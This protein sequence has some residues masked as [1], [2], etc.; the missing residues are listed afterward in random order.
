MSDSAQ[1]RREAADRIHSAAIHLLRRVHEVDAEAMG[2]SPARASALSVLVFGGARSLTELAAAERVTSA[3]M[4]KLVTGMEGEG[5]VRRYPDVNDA[6]S[7]RLEATAKG[8]RILK[9]G[10]TRRLDLLERLLSNAS[11]TEIAAIRIAATAVERAIGS[12]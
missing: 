11:E 2:I 3:T 4:S 10:R 1:H 9:R 8:R 12:A 5:L 7:V 6:R